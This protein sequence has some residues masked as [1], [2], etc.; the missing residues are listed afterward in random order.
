MTLGCRRGIK[1]I[2][3]GMVILCSSQ[4]TT[5]LFFHAQLV[6]LVR[7]LLLKL[8][9]ERVDLDLDTVH[10]SVDCVNIVG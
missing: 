10:S 8:N 3:Q 4:F 7:G 2:F 5:V 1:I 6:I 9:W